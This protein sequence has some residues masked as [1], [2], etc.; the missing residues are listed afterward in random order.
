MTNIKRLRETLD[1]NRE[2]LAAVLGVSLNTVAR[3]EAGHSPGRLAEREI[4]RFINEIKS[5]QKSTDDGA[6]F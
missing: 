3:W 1:I 2:T 4:R 5:G 6:P